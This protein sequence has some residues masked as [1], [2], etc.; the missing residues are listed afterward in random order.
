M[1]NQLNSREVW[2]AVTKER[3]AVLG[4]VTARNECRTVGII[5]AAHDHK[6]Y[7]GT[8]RD[9]WKTRHV[10]ANPHVSITI[11]IAKRIPFV[12]WVKI[13]AATITFSGLAKVYEKDELPP[14]VSKKVFNYV[15]HNDRLMATTCL[16]EVTPEKDFLTYGIG[17][18]MIQMRDHEKAR[19]R[20]PVQPA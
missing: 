7:I 3:F 12:P 8:D 10:Q 19:A 15:D 1:T 9:A 16:I 4:M 18:P 17:I 2:D 20:V 11:P 14:V 13:P 6:I 5:Y